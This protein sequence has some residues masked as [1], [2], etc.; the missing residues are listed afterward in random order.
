[1]ISNIRGDLKV[2]KSAAKPPKYG[3]ILTLFGG[4]LMLLWGLVSIAGLPL[5]FSLLHG[6]LSNDLLGGASVIWG[7]LAQNDAY[8]MVLGRRW[9]A[10]AAIVMG[11]LNIL[12]GFDLFFVWSIVVIIGGI[13]GYMHK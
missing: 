11:I 3:F 9:A 13:L 4:I 5:G 8:L 6:I 2:A 12:D 1:M 10:P 7:G